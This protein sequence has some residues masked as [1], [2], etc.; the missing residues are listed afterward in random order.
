M[1]RK[2]TL[3][4]MLSILGLGDQRASEALEKG[5]PIVGLLVGV[6]MG[7][8]FYH[9]L[10]KLAKD[11]GFTRE[12]LVEASKE[13]EVFEFFKAVADEHR[14]CLMEKLQEVE[15]DAKMAAPP[16]PGETVH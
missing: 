8:L 15:A 9:A 11:G 3:A 14:E 5:G 13:P 10:K 12:E 2:H 1:D 4:A 7:H 16:K 6:E